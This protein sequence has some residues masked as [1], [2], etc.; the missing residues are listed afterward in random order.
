[1]Q[2]GFLVVFMNRMEGF[3]TEVY[4][5]SLRKECEQLFRY[6]RIFTQ[7]HVGTAQSLEGAQRDIF[8]ISQG[9]GNETEHLLEVVFFLELIDTTCSIDDL[10]AACEEWMAFVA[11]LDL[12]LR[13][14]GKY[15]EMVSAGTS[16]F[17]LY[18]FW[19]DTFSHHQTFC[20]FFGA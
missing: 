15:H 8:E 18:I 3:A 5:V 16:H 6:T 1:M 20:K 14:V 2:K 7:Y 9:C 12:E 19:V 13:L 17:T 4:M 11:D 10:L